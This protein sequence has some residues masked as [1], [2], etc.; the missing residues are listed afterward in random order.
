MTELL[1]PSQQLGPPALADAPDAVSSAPIDEE[2][3]P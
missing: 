2:T 1:T 3:T